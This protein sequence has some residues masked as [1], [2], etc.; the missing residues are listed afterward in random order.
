MFE[1][2]KSK[3]DETVTKELIRARQLEQSMLRFRRFFIGADGSFYL[4]ETSEAF[5]EI[6]TEGTDSIFQW[7]SSF[8][9]MNSILTCI[10]D[11]GN[12][13]VEHVGPRMG[14]MSGQEMV[15]VML[16]GRFRK[17]EVI[18]E[19]DEATTGWNHRIENATKNGNF[20]YFPMPSFP[21][22]SVVRA[23]ANIVIYHKNE[24]LFQM[25]YVYHGSLDCE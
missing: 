3:Q 16:K 19:I 24:E 18:I 4:D 20:I 21:N 5:S 15:Y 14:P 22:P 8:K 9:L 2:I 12:L 7:K 11:Y 1:L 25:P 23:V 10:L 13:E 17:E 6:M